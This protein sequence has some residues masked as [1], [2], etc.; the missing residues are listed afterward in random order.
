ME[1]DPESAF[2]ALFGIHK[3]TLIRHITTSGAKK[4]QYN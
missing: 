3:N 2:V 1:T 4:E